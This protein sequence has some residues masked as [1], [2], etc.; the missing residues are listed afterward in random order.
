MTVCAV[1]SQALRPATWSLLPPGISLAGGWEWLQGGLV[2]VRPAGQAITH[3]PLLRSR[4][5]LMRLR[6]LRAAVRFLSQ[7]LLRATP[8]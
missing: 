1:V 5:R 4:P 7:A 2:R 3:A 8:R 6:R